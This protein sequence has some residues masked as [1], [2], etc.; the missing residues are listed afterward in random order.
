MTLA[1]MAAAPAIIAIHALAAVAALLL[2]IVQ[3]TL[4]KGGRR[5]RTLGWIWAALLATVAVTSFGISGERFRFGPFSWI[6]GLSVFTLVMLPIG[7]WAAHRGNISRH[8]GTMVGLF[9]GALLIAGLFTLSPGRII[10][11]MI[12]GG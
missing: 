10:G 9:V 7:L 4:R 1:P 5:H 2:G 12:F 8:R 11:R 3:L 6:H